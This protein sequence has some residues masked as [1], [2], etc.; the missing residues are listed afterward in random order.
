MSSTTMFLALLSSATRAQR[1]ARSSADRDVVTGRASRVVVSKGPPGSKE[2]RREPRHATNDHSAQTRQTSFRFRS[3]VLLP[4][5]FPPV[6]AEGVTRNPPDF[7]A[8]GE[9]GW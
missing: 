3:R 2:N 1:M 6:S 7:Q 8:S 9:R 5:Y 4:L